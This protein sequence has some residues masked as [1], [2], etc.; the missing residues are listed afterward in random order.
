MEAPGNGD[1]DA[2]AR[3]QALFNE[4][5]LGCATCHSGP[6]LTSNQTVDV[7]TG[8]GG[9]DTGG[10]AFQVPSLLGIAWRAPYMHQGCAATLEDRFGPCGGG[11]RHGQTSKLTVAQRSDLIAYLETL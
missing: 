5:N 11:D 4:P 6:R 1:A 9:P 10:G 2:V 3:G 8:G 7:N